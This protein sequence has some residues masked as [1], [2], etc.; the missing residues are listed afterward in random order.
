[1]AYLIDQNENIV[2]HSQYMIAC[3]L[4]H[5]VN[6]MSSK[7]LSHNKQVHKIRQ[8][9]KKARALLL[10]LKPNLKNKKDFIILNNYLKN[11]AKKLSISRDQK[12]MYDTVN[13]IIKRHKLKKKKYQDIKKHIKSIQINKPTKIKLSQIL[14]DTANCKKALNSSKIKKNNII[15]LQNIISKTYKKVLKLQ[16]KAFLHNKAKD[17]HQY[18]KW[19]KYYTYLMQLV[20]KDTKILEQLA[21]ILGKEHDI[22]VLKKYLKDIDLSQKK[23]FICYLNKEQNILREDI[24][25]LTTNI[26]K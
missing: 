20:N 1:M 23:S 6:I 25:I 24:K 26:L 19:I 11:L 2:K 4:D 5:I 14:K 10:V 16:N 7:E 3:Q 8:R 17:F 21:D 12:V 18:R 9:C 15:S 22:T 13:K